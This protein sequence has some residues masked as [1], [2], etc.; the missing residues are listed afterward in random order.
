VSNLSPKAGLL[1]LRILISA[2]LVI[3]GTYRLITGGVVPFGGH[4]AEQGL[5]FGVA[6]ASFITGIEIAGGLS[7]MAGKFIRPLVGWFVIEL[8]LGIAMVHAREGWFVVGGG[9]NGMEYSVVLIGGLI[10]VGL[11]SE[12]WTG[13]P[14]R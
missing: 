5:P 7:L 3:H 13:P 8:V 6:I 10:I 4:L 9:R 2:Q 14:E 11:T 12:G 1:A